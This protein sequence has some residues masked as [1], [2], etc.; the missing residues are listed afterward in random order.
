MRG[1]DGGGTPL[2]AAG[3]GTGARRIGF[4]FDGR[5]L[6]ASP[7][8]TVASALLANG[9]RSFRRSRVLGQPRGVLCGIGTCFDCLVDIGDER[10]VRACIRL[11]AE[12]DVV[13]TSASVGSA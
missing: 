1:G 2:L 8:A 9:V 13:T 6:W 5:Q 12:G 4:S 11:V 3:P 7:G 10:A